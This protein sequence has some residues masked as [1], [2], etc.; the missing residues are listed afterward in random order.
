MKLLKVFFRAAGD[1]EFRALAFITIVLL[2]SG[3]MFYS[4]EEGW[5]GVDSFYFC[6]MTMTT[7]GYGDLA[8]TTVYSKLFTIMYS[9]MS[10]GVF[11]SLAAKLAAAMMKYK[12]DTYA[13]IRNHHNQTDAPRK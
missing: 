3:S 12:S 6:V 5:G 1:K 4:Y 9:F 2:V 11:V 8:P 13:R 10:I 7:I